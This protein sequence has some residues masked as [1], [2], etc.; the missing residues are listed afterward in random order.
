LVWLSFVLARRLAGGMAGAAAAVIVASSPIVLYQAVQPMNDITCAAL[1]MTALVAATS[2]SAS[3]ASWAG[4]LTGVAILV[5]PNLAALAPITLIA[6]GTSLRS[7]ASFCA[8]AIP[9][10]AVL[11]GLNTRLYGSPF[12]SGYGDPTQLFSLSFA[13]Q[14]LARYG[15]SLWETE[16]VLPAL[17]L[18]APFVL[19]MPVRRV[20]LSA[21]ALTLGCVATYLF[22]WPFPEW[23]YL[24]FL[25]PGLVPLLVLAS[26][27]AVRV[28]L[29]VRMGG[30][31]AIATVIVALTGFRTARERHAFELQKL[32]GRFRDMGAVVTSRLPETAVVITV[33]ESGSVRFHA[34][35]EIV[36]WDSLDPEWLD[37][38]VR[39]LE[40]RGRPAYILVERREESEFRSRFRDHS[41]FG[42]LDWPP[43]FDLNR[44]V[45]IFAA[46]DRAR[47][48]GGET[49]STE[50]VRPAVR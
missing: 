8:A 1:W 19:P 43:R 25:L 42:A 35:R 4:L 28:A 48:L 50:N 30:V 45:R 21:L 46:A 12:S 33:W 39:W 7:M 26:A 32:E 49:Y 3:R 15:Q 27:A 47:H 29:N 41:A 11:L 37:R 34:R 18:M 31:V 44:Q 38:A 24:R 36:M 2:E 16:N 6:S 20:A 23:S 9:G 17:G 5:R 22:Y 14:N 13:G 40:E 10:V